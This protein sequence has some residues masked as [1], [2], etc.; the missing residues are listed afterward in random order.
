LELN[1][2]IVVVGAGAVGAVLGTLLHADGHRVWFWVRR[3]RRASLTRISVD[4]VGVSSDRI[5][6]PRCISPGDPVPSSDWILVCVRGEQ[7]DGALREVVQQ[8][9]GT[10]RVAIAAVSLRGVTEQA[11]AAGLTGPVFALHASFGA[12]ADARDSARFHWFP[13]V[14][15]TTVTPDGDRKQLPAARELARALA[16]AGLP[17]SAA[18][19]MSRVMRFVVAMTSVLALGWDLSDWELARLAKDRALRLQTAR[20]MHEA[21]QLVLAGRGWKRL[22]PWWAFGLLLSVLP[23]ALGPKGREAWLHHGPKIRPQTD[24][25]VR[26]LL[27]LQRKAGPAPA[28]NALQRLFQRWLAATSREP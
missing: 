15:P 20:A 1:V 6:A 25:V 16:R 19:S 28:A 22:L 3:A 12:F 10:R 17:T 18:S 5:D 21:A 27:A 9:G 14:P 2:D 24:H 11:R 4:R 13:F 23:R 7:L 26:E 8:M